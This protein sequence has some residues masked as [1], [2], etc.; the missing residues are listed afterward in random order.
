MESHPERGLMSVTAANFWDWT[1]RVQT[2]RH[3]VGLGSLETSLSGHGEPVRVVGT[4]VTDG[5][6]AVMGV[7]PAIGR[8]F[9]DA[10]FRGE[11]RVA[12]ISDAPWSRQFGARRDAV[13]TLDGLPHTLLGVMPRTLTLLIAPRADAAPA[14]AALREEATRLDPMQALS[15]ARPVDDI[16]QEWMAQPRLRSTIANVFGV[17]ALVLTLVGL[18]TRVSWSVWARTREWAV[19]QAVWRSAWSGRAVGRRRGAG[20]GAAPHERSG[21]AGDRGGPARSGR[22]GSCPGDPDPRVGCSGERLPAGPP[23]RPCRSCT[24]TPLGVGA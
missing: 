16:R 14:L 24:G 6:F 1:S 21:S 22:P 12:I 3:V 13:E 20:R 17:S 15:A 2:L 19:R 4:K 9:D 8:A 5:F 10:D 11:R 18:W 23:G 7:A